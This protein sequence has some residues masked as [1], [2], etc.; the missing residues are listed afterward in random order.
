MEDRKNSNNLKISSKNSYKPQVQHSTD[1][2]NNDNGEHS[3]REE[4]SPNNL[5]E[6]SLEDQENGEAGKGSFVES[7]YSG[8][9]PMIEMKK[10]QKHVQVQPVLTK[11]NENKFENMKIDNIIEN[12]IS[13][14]DSI[15]SE[16][17]VFSIYGNDN[18]NGNNEERN[19]KEN[20]LANTDNDDNRSENSQDS[21][22][23]V[24]TSSTG[25]NGSV[26]NEKSEIE[27]ESKR[28]NHRNKREIS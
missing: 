4:R 19:R 17:S 14:T 5:E 2:D 7:L 3:Y 28:N 1:N 20:N 13:R 18:E 6:H 15:S 23:V 21:K 22:S 8:R 24:S 25:S 9:N 11:E 10:L 16:G 12:K 27:E 26:S